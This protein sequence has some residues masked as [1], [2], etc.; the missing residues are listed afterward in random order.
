MRTWINENPVLATGVAAG[1]LALALGVLLAGA[2]PTR[3]GGPAEVYFWDLETNE[4]F[5]GQ[6]DAFPPLT[7]PSGGVGVRAHLFTC[8][9]C[10]P[11]EWFGYLETYT[12]EAWAYFEEEGE[13]PGLETDTLVRAL[14]GDRWIPAASAAAERLYDAIDAVCP[15]PPRLCRP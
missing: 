13:F 3:A 14:D 12:D 6:G 11:D 15:T 1:L 10:E 5:A 7:A 9:E 8:G 2:W 4:P